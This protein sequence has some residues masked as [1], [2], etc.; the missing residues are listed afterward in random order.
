M[1]S[2][3]CSTAA[4]IITILLGLSSGAPVQ[5]MSKVRLLSINT[6]FYVQAKP[7]LSANAGDLTTDESTQFVVDF[8]ADGLVTIRRVSELSEFLS[9]QETDHS[10]LVSYTLEESG[11]GGALIPQLNS[12]INFEYHYEPSIYS[13]VLRV[14][15]S[16]GRYCYLAFE[17]NGHLVEE[18]CSENLDLYKAR[19]MLVAI[20]E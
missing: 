19:V 17:E 18:P 20:R 5:R 16:N 13:T 11:S 10:G 12:H 9:V 6:G 3:M 7:E 14:R 4:V 2:A 1:N 15:H 8:T